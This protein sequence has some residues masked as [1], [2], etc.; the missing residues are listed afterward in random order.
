[1]ATDTKL[2]ETIAYLGTLGPDTFKVDDV[3]R[4]RL[5]DA[6]QASLARILTPY[7]RSWQLAVTDAT[8]HAARRTLDD[9]GIW[10]GWV[11][12]GME[13][14]SLD[15][16]AGFCNT[17]CDHELLRKYFQIKSPPP[18]QRSSCPGAFLEALDD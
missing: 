13:E 15:D 18:F 1:M 6:A 10:E 3:N 8:V 5:I 17:P 4:L 9:L 7:E 11:K 16:L 12:S 2:E 14:V